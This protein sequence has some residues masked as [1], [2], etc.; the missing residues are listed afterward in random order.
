[1][2]ALFAFFIISADFIVL[3]SIHLGSYVNG[4]AFR[5]SAVWADENY[6]D[7]IYKIDPNTMQIITSFYYSGGLDGLGFDGTYL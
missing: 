7:Y 5:N 4:V 6:A 2:S 1:M 3:D